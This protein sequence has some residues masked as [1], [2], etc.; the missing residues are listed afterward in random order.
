LAE[1]DGTRA[2]LIRFIG[3]IARPGQSAEGL[4]DDQ[5]LIDAGVID[6]LAMVQIIM[7]LEREHGVDLL[8]AGFDPAELASVAGIRKVIASAEK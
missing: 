7:Y 6:S 8:K 3:T 4:A 1:V 2:A 5:N